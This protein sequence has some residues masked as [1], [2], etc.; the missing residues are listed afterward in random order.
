M[1]TMSAV[2]DRAT[3]MHTQAASAAEGI[4]PPGFHTEPAIIGKRRQVLP[5]GAA[6]VRAKQSMWDKPFCFARLGG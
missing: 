5:P 1:M 3:G 6:A 2:V 4:Q